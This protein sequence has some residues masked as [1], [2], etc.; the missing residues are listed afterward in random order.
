MPSRQQKANMTALEKTNENEKTVL[1]GYARLSNTGKAVN[2]SIKKEVIEKLPVYETNE[3][4]SYF[5]LF[6]TIKNIDD[7]IEGKKDVTAVSH[8]KDQKEDD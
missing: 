3:G 5:N 8:W 4:V 2:L 7:V 6:I 1:V